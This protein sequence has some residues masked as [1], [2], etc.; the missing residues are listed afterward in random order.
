MATVTHDR[1]DWVKR[2]RARNWALLV[3]LGAMVLLFYV[4]GMIKFGGGL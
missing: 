1:D 4:L 2:R 3:A